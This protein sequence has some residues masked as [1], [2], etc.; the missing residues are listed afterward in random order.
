M[1]TRLVLGLIAVSGALPG[2]AAADS[3]PIGPGDST[4]AIRT[5]L[6]YTK[7]GGNTDNSAG[8]FLF[9]AAHVMGKWKLLLGTEALYGS[10]KG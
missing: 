9:H 7:T 6:G 1:R 5:V 8:N 2:I 3:A 4:W 10:T